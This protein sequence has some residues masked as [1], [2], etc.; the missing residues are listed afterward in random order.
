MAIKEIET[1]M[2]RGPVRVHTVL[3]ETEKG[4][5]ATHVADLETLRE[6]PEATVWVVPQL[7]GGVS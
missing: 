2:N 4:K 1:F 7:V 5:G 3:M 6:H